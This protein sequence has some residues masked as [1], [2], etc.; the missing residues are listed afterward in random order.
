MSEPSLPSVRRLRACPGSHW[1]SL[2]RLGLGRPRPQDRLPDRLRRDPPTVSPSF[3]H[4][5]EPLK[6]PRGKGR[7]ECPYDEPIVWQAQ[8]SQS[9]DNAISED[10]A[11]PLTT[12]RLRWYDSIANL[13]HSGQ[14]R[15]IHV[16]RNR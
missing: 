6:N 5:Q 16:V 4:L 8:D 15:P 12:V 3:Q 7:K 2:S 9:E 10:G 11:L 13:S 1:N 14:R